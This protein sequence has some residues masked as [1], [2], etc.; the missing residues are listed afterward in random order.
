MNQHRRP[1]EGGSDANVS[2]IAAPRASDEGTASGDEQV[3]CRP[4]SV[5]AAGDPRAADELMDRYGALIWS[6]ARRHTRRPADAEDAVQ[7]IFVE[8]WRCADRYDP[9]VAAEATLLAELPAD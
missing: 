4:G 7:E 3:A 1:L 8:L 6:L 9:A 5:D 2:L